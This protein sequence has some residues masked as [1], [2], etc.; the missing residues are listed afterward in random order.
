MERKGFFRK[1]DRREKFPGHGIVLRC[2]G[3]FGEEMPYPDFLAK[4]TALVVDVQFFHQGRL[5]APCVIEN[6]RLQ[7]VVAVDGFHIEEIDGVIAERTSLQR[8]WRGG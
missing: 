4:T 6:P 5:H 3:E 2:R 8:S 1:L 7:Y